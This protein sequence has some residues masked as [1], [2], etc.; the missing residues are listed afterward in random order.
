MAKT[1]CDWKKRD[2]IRNPGKLEALIEDPCYLC[3]KCGRAANTPKVLCRPKPAFQR[4][5]A[6]AG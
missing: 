4:L 2:I 5:L 6:K 3:M 1:I